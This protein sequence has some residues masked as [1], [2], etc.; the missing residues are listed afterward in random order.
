MPSITGF[1]ITQ[2]AQA[3]SA[4][5]GILAGFAFAVLVWLIEHLVEL[6]GKDTGERSDDIEQF[7]KIKSQ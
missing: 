5:A 4:V 6:K 7:E 3:Y 2:V 1:D